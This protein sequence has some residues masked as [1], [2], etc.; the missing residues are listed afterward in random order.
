MFGLP[1][2]CALDGV[3]VLTAATS[4]AYLASSDDLAESVQA[5]MHGFPCIY[6]ALPSSLP[7]SASR[8]PRLEPLPIPSWASDWLPEA[9]FCRRKM[10]GW[11]QTHILKTQAL[12]MLLTKGLDVLLLDADRR[13]IGNPMPGFRASDSDVAALRDEAFLNFGLMYIRANERTVALARRVANRSL[14]AWD[15]AVFAEE[16][17]AAHERGGLRC[18]HANA[19]VRQCVM[20][21]ERMHRLNKESAEGIADATQ[22]QQSS[23]CRASGTFSGGGGGG[24][25]LPLA[26]PPAFR[27]FQRWSTRGYNELPVAL[28]RY[29][30]C[31]R[32]ACS[33]GPEE[34]ETGTGGRV[35]PRLCVGVNGTDA[36]HPRAR[37]T[38]RSD[39]PQTASTHS[40]RRQPVPRFATRDWQAHR[41]PTLHCTPWP[42]GSEGI[43]NDAARCA[44]GN[45]LRDGYV[46]VHNAHRG[47]S[48]AACGRSALCICCRRR[49][50]VAWP[51]PVSAGGRGNARAT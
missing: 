24:R 44:R 9:A 51:N 28:R 41:T 3:A 46:Y 13:A 6:I 49:V 16:V 39:V 29:S 7:F 40:L 37:P 48:R 31:S 36:I 2:T 43:K 50:I 19:W 21:A 17:A 38:R 5:H 26:P 14:G 1:R 23:R 8:H 10:S 11:R 30:H 33:L 25:G 27:L 34:A 12:L 22:Q 18:C 32:T 4:V 45:M 15:Q 47:T 35:L 42:V 20:I